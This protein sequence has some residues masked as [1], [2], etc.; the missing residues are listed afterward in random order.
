MFDCFTFRSP[1]FIWNLKH[2]SLSPPPP[3][4]PLPPFKDAHKFGAQIRKSL[5]DLIDLMSPDQRESGGPAETRP[6][7]KK[8][9]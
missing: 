5:N 1:G 9:Q 3:T 8:D 7:V 6:Q 2:L 4:P